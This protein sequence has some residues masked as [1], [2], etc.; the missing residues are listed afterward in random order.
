MLKKRLIF[1]LLYGDGYFMLSRN[2]R[3]QKVGDIDWLNLNYNFSKISFEI[4]ELIVLDVSR[5]E[6]DL[7]KFC[8]IL[9]ALSETCFVPLSIG[10]GIKSVDY[11]KQLISAGADKLVLNTA[12]FTDPRL[13]YELAET[14][15]EQ[16]LIAEVDIKYSPVG[17]PYLLINSGTEVVPG[18]ASKIVDYVLSLPIGELMINSVDK[19]GTGQ[20]FDFALLNLLPVSITKPIIFSGGVGNAIHIMNGLE[21]A[22]IDAVNTANLF[23]FIGDGLKNARQNLVQNGHNAPIW[24]SQLAENL[25]GCLIK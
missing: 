23:N 13:V 2:F 21:D 9:T 3:L 14:Y 20:G 7:D 1:T 19:D 4:D 18:E 5:N 16:C 15:G 24:N 22:R 6:R 25:K 17:K 12:L 8:S 10:G 11:A